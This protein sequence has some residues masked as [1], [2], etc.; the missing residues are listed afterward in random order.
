MWA[1]TRQGI[2]RCPKKY[3]S[4]NIK[5]PLFNLPGS[6]WG[7]AGLEQWNVSEADTWWPHPLPRVPAVCGRCNQT[8]KSHPQQMS[9]GH[10]ASWIKETQKIKVTLVF[11]VFTQKNLKRHFEYLSKEVDF[12]T[13]STWKLWGISTGAPALLLSS[14]AISSP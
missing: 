3:F 10:F 14:M 2:R 13:K 7:Q 8:Q 5:C 4:W 6:G 11:V 12:Q 9:W 1:L